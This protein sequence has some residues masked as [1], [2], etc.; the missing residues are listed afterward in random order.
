MHSDG[1]FARGS[2]RR[3]AA[4][5]AVAGALVVAAPFAVLGAGAAGGITV[6][7][8]MTDTN[9]CTTTLDPAIVGPTAV[10]V[11]VTIATDAAP[12]PHAGQVITLSNTTVGISIP[13]ALIQTGVDAGLVADGDSVP[14]TLTLVLAGSN[15]SEGTHT[16]TAPAN[17]VVHVVNGVAQPLDAT[18][19]L[20]STTWT[21]LNAASDV[22]FTE[23]SATDVAT[24]NIIGGITVT[25]ACTPSASAGAIV[26]LQGVP[27]STTTTVL[28]TTT[29]A[30][31]ATTTSVLPVT[32]TSVPHVTTTT[33]TVPHV[34]TTTSVP[35]VTTTTTTTPPSG[36]NRPGYGYGDKNHVHCG[37]PGSAAGPARSGH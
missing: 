18:I 25:T 3:L 22:V 29:S 33:T 8:S 15:T 13:A 27:A 35:H 21:P 17:F 36:C 10:G 37:P 7:G 24:L 2:R 6:H 4:V 31:H 34:T 12:Q 20:P 30:P 32:T 28:L 16:Y 19:T 5:A 26:L 9:D 1:F 23:Q 14:S 11:N